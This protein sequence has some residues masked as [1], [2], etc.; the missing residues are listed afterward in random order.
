MTELVDQATS[1]PGARRT[2]AP[3]TTRTRRSVRVEDVIARGTRVRIPKGTRIWGTFPGRE[4][5]ARRAY[6]VTVFHSSP[7]GYEAYGT[8]HITWVGAGGYWHEAAV[9]DVEVLDDA[10]SRPTA[11]AGA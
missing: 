4:R 1:G 3:A 2:G 7:V 5:T 6:V 8:P 10:T 9:A 11:P